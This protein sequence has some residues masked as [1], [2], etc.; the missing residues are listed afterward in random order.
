MATAGV[1]AIESRLKVL[2][3]FKFEQQSLH[4]SKV[5]AS[6]HDDGEDSS[7]SESFKS[8]HLASA[9]PH[10]AD[11]SAIAMKRVVTLR[12]CD[13]MEQNLPAN[14][15][16]SRLASRF[17]YTQELPATAASPHTVPE[18]ALLDSPFKLSSMLVGRTKFAFVVDGMLQPE[19]SVVVEANRPLSFRVWLDELPDGTI[20]P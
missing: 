18:Q 17:R 10:G 14:V 2:D 20:R 15:Y 3:A 7:D 8:L 11:L 13:Q 1:K 5:H 6:K 12:K 16:V 9:S 19:L 4:E